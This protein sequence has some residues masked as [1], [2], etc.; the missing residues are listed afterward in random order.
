MF[1]EKPPYF[2][3]RDGDVIAAVAFFSEL[4]PRPEGVHDKVWEII[5]KC[6]ALNPAERPTTRSI[7]SEFEG[8]GFSVPSSPRRPANELD[9]L[10]ISSFLVDSAERLINQVHSIVPICIHKRYTELPSNRILPGR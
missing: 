6:W 7:I 10:G 5:E 8:C 3:K 1:T 4:P 9:T 2:D